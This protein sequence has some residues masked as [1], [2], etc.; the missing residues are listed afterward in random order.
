VAEPVAE[1]GPAVSR[2]RGFVPTVLVGL[3]AGTLAALS[4]RQDWARSDVT[5]GAGA[6]GS[7]VAPAALALALVSLAAWGVLLV[8]RRA[9]RRVAAVLG[10]AAS[11]GV[12]AVVVT[13]PAEARAA[14]LRA[15]ATALAGPA[16]HASLTGWFLLA[17]VSAALCAGC[18]LVAA[19]AAGRWPEMS[20]RYDAPAG[21]G[22]RTGTPQ[23]AWR[24]LDE[25]RDPT[26]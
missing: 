22:G 12:L 24:A 25:G 4:A 19:V 7:D 13:S 6:A 9:A 18:L 15:Q 1:P 23:D 11:L 21:G 14:A 20:R 5:D 10:A 8:V 26:V 2:S 16:D 17:A 3:T